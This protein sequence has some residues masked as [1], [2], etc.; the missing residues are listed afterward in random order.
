M[1]QR[2]QVVLKVPAVVYK[3]A[4]N[5]NNKPAETLAYHCQWLYGFTAIEKCFDI[6]QHIKDGLNRQ[7]KDGWVITYRDMILNIMKSVGYKNPTDVRSLTPYWQNGTGIIEGISKDYPD[8]FKDFDNNDG[9]FFINISKT[10]ELSYCFYR[11]NQVDGGGDERI[12]DSQEYLLNY[13]PKQK[14]WELPIPSLINLRKFEDET[15]IKEFPKIANPVGKQE[16]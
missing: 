2:F 7:I 16:G 11:P 5:P 8:L 10:N 13:Y 6:I 15:L 1:G 14:W 3:Q 12:L 9:I 4:D